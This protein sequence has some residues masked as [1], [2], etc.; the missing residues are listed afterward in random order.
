MLGIAILAAGK[1]KRMNSV[2]KPKVLV[3]FLGKPLL[4]YV[5]ETA[6]RINPFKVY[7]VVGFKKE[8][9]IDFINQNYNLNNIVIVE[10]KE[11]LGTG[12]AILQ[13]EPVLEKGIDNLLILS[14]D[15][16]LISF[17]TLL[18]FIEFHKQGN[19]DLSL[20]STKLEN[21]T[22][23]GR[24]VRDTNG[25][26]LRIVEQKDLKFGEQLIDEINSGIYI[27]KTKDLFDYLR[28]LKNENA[29]SEYY[30]T[31]IVEMY[32]ADQKRVGAF[33]IKSSTE[34]LGINTYEEL[35]N[36]EKFF[37]QNEI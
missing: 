27:V 15:V 10:Q 32:T 6:F 30:L 28:K 1:G 20:I 34:V 29:Q 7:V 21:P 9:V 24:I 11:Q 16:P 25:E 22:G 19:Y 26:L 3:D 36:L 17:E 33:F 13:L 8:A 12:H 31:D 18:K 14:G 23:Y 5:L 4:G 2:D 35:K 37:I